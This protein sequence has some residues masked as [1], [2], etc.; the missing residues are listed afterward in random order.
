MSLGRLLRSV[1]RP[2][3][4]AFGV[5]STALEAGLTLINPRKLTTGR[6]A[7]YRTAVGAV[8]AWTV[9]VTLRDGAEESEEAPFDPLGP[10][11]RIALSTG[12]AGTALGFAD[13]GEAVDARLHDAIERA[14]AK[15]P[16]VWLAATTAALSAGAWWLA[17]QG[18]RMGADDLDSWDDFE[19]QSEETLPLPIEVRQLAA[20]L[21]AATEQ[22]SSPELRKQLAAA[23]AL[24]YDGEPVSSSFAYFDVPRDLPRVVPGTS[25]FPVIGRFRA[26]GDHTFDI[27]ITID[28]GH[29]SSIDIE[30]G[31]DWSPEEHDAWDDSD[32][33]IT[34][35]SAWPAPAEVELLVETPAGVRPLTQ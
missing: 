24:S 12:A 9:W 6:R 16:R 17:R 15:H 30:E 29:L 5:V 26:F 19:E 13:A 1:N 11:G 25:T 3:S 35:L 27:N 31:A 10:V 7:A 8:T 32:A 4:V 20:H 22:H 18:D 21:L 2:S 34:D 23:E 33:D 28:Q 14:G